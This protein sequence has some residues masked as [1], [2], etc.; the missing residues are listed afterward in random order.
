VPFDDDGADDR[1]RFRPPPHP[2][3]RL[4]RHPSELAAERPLVPA[5]SPDRHRGRPWAMVAVAGTAGAVLAGAGVLALGVGERTVERPVVERVAMDTVASSV[6]SAEATTDSVHQRV[7]PA[8]VAVGAGGSGVV[9]RDDGIVLTSAALADTRG[10][11]DVRLADGSSTEAEVLGADPATGIGVLD[12]AGRGYPTGVLAADGA[13]AEGQASF[14]V[15]T[16]AAG[17]A[18]TAAALVGASRRYRT[19]GGT[20]LD[21]VVETSS[22]APAEAVGA[23]LVDSRGAVVGIVTAVDEGRAS[24]V[25]PVDVARKVS[26]DL[27]ALGEVA[28]C[29][30]G[31]EGSDADG[32]GAYAG[33]VT[34]AEVV[35]DSPAERGG[36]RPHDVLV[37]LDQRTITQVPDL[38]LALRSHS[39]GDRVDAVVVRDGARVTLEVT[40]SRQAAPRH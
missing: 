25:V 12:L 34:I 3:D 4:W 36:L 40:L 19:P 23:P 11:V 8:V 13:L 6:T 22:D 18:T 39:P 1:F 26:D 15:S 37:E 5:T 32:V 17:G 16:G 38:M 7:A 35:A 30:L 10:P 29:W 33:G 2:D 24:Y 20:T 14:T 27:L 31:I 9:V 21:A 28:H